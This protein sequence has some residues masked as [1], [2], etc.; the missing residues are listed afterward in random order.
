MNVLA[1]WE[2]DYIHT[3]QALH[4]LGLK[5]DRWK[6]N[7]TATRTVGGFGLQLD[8]PLT[9]GQL[10]AMVSKTVHINSVITELL[11]FLKGDTN[12]AYLKE[13][14]CSIWN[15][16]ATETGDLGPV[17]GEQWRS[18]QGVGRGF[19]DQIAKLIYDLKN[20]PTSRR[21]IVSAWNPD[22][23][24]DEA[25]SPQDNVRAGRQ[26]LAPCHMLFQ[27]YVEDLTLDD[28]IAAARA[29]EVSEAVLNAITYMPGRGEAAEVLNDYEVPTRGLRLR[30]D[31]RS[32]D[33]FL[34]V[35]FNILSYALLTHI[36]CEA[37]GNLVP[38]ALCMQFGDYHLYEDQMDAA[39][40]QIDRYL[41]VKKGTEDGLK[42]LAGLSYPK[43][44]FPSVETW[45]GL[46]T[47][48][49]EDIEVSGYMPWG[50]ILA[51]VAI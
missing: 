20:N 29:M 50:R 3:L 14:G 48:D 4:A 10:P 28:R 34:G 17:Y 2:R 15:G 5:G 43:V 7:R 12:I 37:V 6:G 45:Q 13:N 39:A 18:W 22:N 19:I 41:S 46:E 8:V 16:W 1:Q 27:V 25:T 30:V 11:W 9:Y 26:A 51:P 21:M 47:I 42:K 44:Q 35:P 32:A 24:P 38:L 31:Q 49:R 33:W 23:L 36:L 40:E